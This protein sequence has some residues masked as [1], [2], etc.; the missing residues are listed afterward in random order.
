MRELILVSR[1]MGVTLDRHG[2]HKPH[3]I[4]IIEILSIALEIIHADGHYVPLCVH[5]MRVYPQVFGL[6]AWSENCKRYSSLPLDAIVSLFC[7]TV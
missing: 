6:A 3:I 2:P 7:E 5:Y 1:K 4:N